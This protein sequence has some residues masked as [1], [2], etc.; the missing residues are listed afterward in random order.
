MCGCCFGK[1]RR[2]RY[3]AS[4][5]LGTEFMPARHTPRDIHFVADEAAVLICFKIALYVLRTR[6]TFKPYLIGLAWGLIVGGVAI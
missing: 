6:G 3:D 1:T 4:V 2:V 5:G